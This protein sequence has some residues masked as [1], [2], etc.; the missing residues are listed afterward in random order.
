MG[1]TDRMDRRHTCRAGRQNRYG[2]TTPLSPFTHMLSN[3]SQA[4]R[5]IVDEG[6]LV[7]DEI[8]VPLVADG[9]PAAAAAA[10]S[11]GTNS[12][13]N[14]SSKGYILDG[15]PRTVAQA[16]ALDAMLA[17]KGLGPIQRAVNIELADWVSLSCRA[18]Q[19][20]H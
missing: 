16:R 10:A 19:E 13:S 12:N 9:L 20:N 4:L 17:A 8:M 1:T 5:R 15:F 14:S 18:M 2:L 7:P 6:G 11:G 3:R